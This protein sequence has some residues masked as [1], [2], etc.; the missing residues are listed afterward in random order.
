MAKAFLAPV[1][2]EEFYDGESDCIDEYTKAF[3]NRADATL[4]A[5]KAILKYHPDEYNYRYD[6]RYF[7][8][9]GVYVREIELVE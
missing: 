8:W 3:T 9:G 4:Y 5:R 1:I 7:T 2:Y 6:N